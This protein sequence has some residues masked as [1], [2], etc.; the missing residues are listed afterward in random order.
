MSIQ[1]SYQ[2]ALY[3]QQ[4]QQYGS[5]AAK[6]LRSVG[7][8]S[9]TNAFMQFIHNTGKFWKKF[10]THTI[11]DMFRDPITPIKVFVRLVILLIV[12]TLAIS[13]W[14]Y[15]K[16]L[17]NNTNVQG[18]IDTRAAV[19]KAQERVN[20]LSSTKEGFQTTQETQI[21]QTTSE[22]K[23][24]ILK[25]LQP[26]TVKQAAY[27]DKVFDTNSG[28][29]QQLALGC[30]S[31]FFNIDYLT[32]DMNRENFSRPYEPALLYRDNSGNLISNNSG[33]LDNAFQHLAEYGFNDQMPNY[34]DPIIVFLHF[35]RT[36]DKLTETDRYVTFLKKVS[37]SLNVLNNRFAKEYYRSSRE[38][39]IFTQ[40]IHTFD[41][42]ILIGTNI[43]TSYSKQLNA[44]GSLT[45][46]EDLDYKINFHY[47]KEGS[48]P[49]DATA[50][51]TSNQVNAL[52]IKRTTLLALTGQ[53]REDWLAT[54]KNN[55]IIMK[56]EP[57]NVLNP[58]E[59]GFL[60][61]TLGVNIVPYDYINT[62][63]ADARNV[64]TIY[65]GSF[66]MKPDIL[67]T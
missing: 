27:L 49:I 7:P 17:G 52:I 56:D 57:T 31:F 36:P 18:F 4:S 19:N 55:F 58:A 45:L 38:S 12:V 64:K 65:N 3:A 1:A 54:H 39:D 15:A 22:A 42:K 48:D 32:A 26:L 24:N 35:V 34:N 2:D 51:S 43:D 53:Q 46:M 66:R 8:P 11:P 10:F 62:P 44:S 61:N 63:L 37:L 21:N 41:T 30:R 40:D 9:T 28:I 23:R 50:I 25:N 6:A 16:G 13:L 14:N 47:Y 20:K 67:I 59:V 5:G 60:L 29:S 33:A